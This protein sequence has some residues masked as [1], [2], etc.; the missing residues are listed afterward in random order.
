[1]ALKPKSALLTLYGDYGLRKGR[2]EIG[3][4]SL[5]ELLGNFGLSE[6][7]IRCSVSRMCRADILKVRHDNNKSYYSLTGAGTGLLETGEQRIFDHKTRHWDGNWSVVT[8]SIPEEKREIRNEFRQELGWLGYGA[9][10]DA[11]WVSP[12]NRADEVEKIVVRL[13]IK[14]NVQVFLAKHLGLTDAHGIVA[15]CWD[16]DRLQQKYADFIEKYR[17][18]SD[19]FQN[20]VQNG[21][22]IKPSECFVERFELIHQYR[23]FPFLDPDLPSELLPDNWLRSEAADLFNKYYSLL[24]E[25][26]NEY[27]DSVFRNYNDS[28]RFEKEGIKS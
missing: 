17:P 5:I 20:R 12:N 16:L 26:A 24:T 11:T 8:Y 18:K 25:K 21:V 28:R 2:G 6:Q 3:I 15:R 14:D 7:A 1:M 13:K 27:F 23:R 22:L 9:L 10:C 19:D 4:G